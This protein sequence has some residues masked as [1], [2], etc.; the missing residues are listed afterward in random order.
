[1]FHYQFYGAVV[2]VADRDVENC[3]SLFPEDLEHIV[4]YGCHF[5]IDFSSA[6]RQCAGMGIDC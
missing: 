4:L 2:G 3:L 5:V 6:S 1:M